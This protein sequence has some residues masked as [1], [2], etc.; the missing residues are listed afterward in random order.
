MNIIFAVIK[1]ELRYTLRDKRTLIS[2][3]L[4]PAILFPLL[5]FGLFKLQAHLIN[6]DRKK[7]LKIAFVEIPE[8]MKAHFKDDTFKSCY[9]LNLETAKKAVSTDSID[10]IIEFST[11]FTAN[12]NQ[13]KSGTLTV[14]YKSTN[15]SIYNR[16][17]EKI[18]VL[19]SQLL[20]TRTKQ[21]NMSTE[22]FTPI[23]ISQVNIASKKEEIGTLFGGFLPYFFILF[24]FFGC[25]Y[26]ALDL[27][28]G[29]KENGT[30]ETLLTV[31]AS[32]FEILFGKMISISLIGLSAA[33]ITILGCGAGLKFLPNIPEDFLNAVSD[34]LSVKFILMLFAMLLPISVFF[35]GLL[36]AVVVHAKSFKE[37]QSYMTPMSF[38]VIIP[39]SIAAAPGVEL[40]W[41]TVWVPVLN[42]ALATKEIISG[43]ILPAQYIAIVLSLTVLGLLAIYIGFKQFSKESC[44]LK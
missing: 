13:L 28:T 41:Q 31:P 7:E 24:C 40:N 26:P 6:K 19:K 17:L 11:D 12:V 9:N 39:V 29:E 27:I 8:T 42:I 23:V 21:L 15:R 43:T 44:V 33:L 37:A 2:S 38:L 20:N 10:A 1:K 25:M 14:Y 4:L 18:D 22:V 35:S 36:S 3:I 16:V 30:M 34:I 5:C 32:R